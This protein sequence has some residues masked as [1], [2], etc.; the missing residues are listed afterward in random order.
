MFFTN[1]LKFFMK[2]GA[3]MTTVTPKNCSCLPGSTQKKKFMKLTPCL[4]QIIFVLLV[5]F[6]PSQVRLRVPIRPHPASAY[7]APP[8]QP[9]GSPTHSS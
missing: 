7:V 2:I 5:L 6:T 8:S 1:H 4:F 3:Q 9:H